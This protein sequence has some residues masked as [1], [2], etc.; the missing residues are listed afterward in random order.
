IQNFYLEFSKEN[1]PQ[2][3][4]QDRLV[5]GMEFFEAFAPDI[6]PAAGVGISARGGRYSNFIDSDLMNGLRHLGGLDENF[7]LNNPGSVQ[8]LQPLA[9]ALAGETET[10]GPWQISPPSPPPVIP[11]VTPPVDPPQPPANS[12]DVRAV[13][14]TANMSLGLSLTYVVMPHVGQ[15][16]NAITP[17]GWAAFGTPEMGKY[18]TATVNAN[19]ELVF[20]LTPDGMTACRSS[21]L[22]GYYRVMGNDGGEHVVQI[23]L[24]QNA[25]VFHSPSFQSQY[26]DD[27]WYDGHRIQGESHYGGW[28]GLNYD[29]P[30]NITS[31]DK[32]DAIH[33]GQIW[34]VSSTIDG[35]DGDD[36]IHIGT[37]VSSHANIIIDG[38][39]GDDEIRIESYVETASFGSVIAINGGDGDDIMRMEGTDLY[40]FSGTVIIDG[41][42]GNDLIRVAGAI[43]DLVTIDGGEGIDA[44][45]LDS[46]TSY[47]SLDALFSFPA[48]AQDME[49]LVGGGSF[50]NVHSLA[51]IGIT[52]NGAGKIDMGGGDWHYDGD[53]GNRA[54]YTYTGADPDYSGVIASVEIISLAGGG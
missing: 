34:D 24:P 46:F 16:G 33:T 52:I 40:L 13:L 36:E 44:L 7:D 14:H 3:Q 53:A 47:G 28:L 51:D 20:A 39:A 48:K 32:D 43:T 8:A 9:F 31:S 12:Y 17:I 6:A 11:P 29:S 30:Y 21:S 15:G 19:G 1:I 23:Y 22:E 26:G 45:F 49:I 50:S 54:H 42:A 27:A 18:L 5:A 2:F 25:N 10:G 4:I 35:G 41:G 37:N 38:G